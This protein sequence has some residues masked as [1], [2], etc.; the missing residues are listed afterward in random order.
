MLP[1]TRVCCRTFRDLFPKKNGDI[2]RY[3]Q[4]CKCV[5]VC[6]RAC[7]SCLAMSIYRVLMSVRH[8]ILADLGEQ[9]TVKVYLASQTLWRCFADVSP[10]KL[11][12]WHCF[13]IS[14][15][16]SQRSHL[17]AN[18]EPLLTALRWGPIELFSDA[19]RHTAQIH[20]CIGDLQTYNSIR[21]A[22]E[23][24]LQ[25]DAHDLPSLNHSVSQW[26]DFPMSLLQWATNEQWDALQFVR[27]I[28][29]DF[30]FYIKNQVGYMF[31]FKFMD[32][33]GSIFV[34]GFPFGAS[35]WNSWNS[36]WNNSWK[37]SWNTI[38]W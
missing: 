22:R 15:H 17:H 35:S 10:R 11:R 24:G 14:D 1:I 25:L 33:V 18:V 7:A 2:G 26:S 29:V 3:K 28:L 38:A 31:R 37:N 20:M 23:W 27:T 19:G 8:L 4:E 13:R 32:V 30:R 36:S 5:Y 6:I 34:D 12:E 9:D 21:V 16:E